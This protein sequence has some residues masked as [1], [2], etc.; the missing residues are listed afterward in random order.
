MMV[1]L[2]LLSIFN[3][4]RTREY[5]YQNSYFVHHQN[6]LISKNGSHG[7]M[8]MN[9]VS[10][11]LQYPETMDHFSVCKEYGDVLELSWTENNEE[12]TSKQM[13]I[14]I[15]LENRYKMRQKLIAKQEDGQASYS[16][17][18]ATGTSVEL[19]LE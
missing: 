6:P 9:G 1:L 17:S 11:A 15:F 19:V 5:Y 18:T 8:K 16:G 13:E 12:N 3:I 10:C 4:N 14:G 2:P 7:N